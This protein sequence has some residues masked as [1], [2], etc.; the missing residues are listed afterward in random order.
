MSLATVWVLTAILWYAKL[1]VAGPHDPAFFYLLPLTFIAARYGMWPALLGAIT[2][3]GCADYFLYDPLYTLK[4][5]SRIELV[6]LSFFAVLAVLAINSASRSP[7]SLSE[8]RTPGGRASSVHATASAG[9]GG[10]SR[11]TS[12]PAV[13]A[14]STDTEAT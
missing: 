8:I 4:I 14:V 2:A 9:D 3:F 6:D 13:D 11:S 7:W 10:L 5:C 12:T 1:V